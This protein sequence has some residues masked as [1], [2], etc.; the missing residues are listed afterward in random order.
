MNGCHQ[1]ATAYNTSH[2]TSTQASESHTWYYNV[3]SAQATTERRARTLSIGIMKSAFMAEVTIYRTRN[4]VQVIGCIV[5]WLLVNFVLNVLVLDRIYVVSS[6]NPFCYSISDVRV[7]KLSDEISFQ[8]VRP[9][10]LIDCCS[11]ASI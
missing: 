5:L 4:I 2:D 7:F 6:L 3:F 9:V 1:S 10:K 8:S 11:Y